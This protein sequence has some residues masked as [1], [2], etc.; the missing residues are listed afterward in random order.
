MALYCNYE[1]QKKINDNHLIGFVM[2]LN[3]YTIA[4]ILIIFGV[5]FIVIN[6]VKIHKENQRL[7]EDLKKALV[8]RKK[9]KKF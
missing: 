3:T 2:I 7:A 8:K 4:I 1:S 5:M 6:F 9:I